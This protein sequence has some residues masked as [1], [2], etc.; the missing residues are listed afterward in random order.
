MAGL[1]AVVGYD[2]TAVLAMAEAR[3]VDIAAVAELM[4]HIEAVMVRKLGEE[5]AARAGA[6][7]SP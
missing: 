5:P 1:G 7:I 4:P 3:G 2:M 6:G